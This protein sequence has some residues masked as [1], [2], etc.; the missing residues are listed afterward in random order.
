MAVA[1]RYKALLEKGEEDDEFEDDERELKEFVTEKRELKECVQ[2]V[3][4]YHGKFSD[5]EDLWAD[6]GV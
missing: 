2:K 6:G 3:S 4:R 5:A 1:R